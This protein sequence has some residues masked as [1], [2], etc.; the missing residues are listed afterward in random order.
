METINYVYVANVR[1]FW[2]EISN[3]LP[4]KAE[5]M[6]HMADHILFIN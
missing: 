1:F 3:A 2:G 4:A 6:L 5:T